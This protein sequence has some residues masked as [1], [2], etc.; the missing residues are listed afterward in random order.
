M[1]YFNISSVD[2]QWQVFNILIRFPL[3]VFIF[4]FQQK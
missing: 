4:R 2:L 3:Q 1:T